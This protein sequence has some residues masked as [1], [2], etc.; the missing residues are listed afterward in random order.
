[1]ST[2]IRKVHLEYIGGSSYKEYNIIVTQKI[3][4][5]YDLKS[6]YGRIG[7]TQ[8]YR[9]IKLDIGLSQVMT[10]Y[11]SILRKKEKKGYEVIS[12]SD[13]S[14]FTYEYVEFLT[15]STNNLLDG[16]VIGIKHHDGILRL[17]KS[18]DNETLEMAEKIIF[19]NLKKLN[20][21]A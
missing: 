21:A 8:V 16:D 12:S 9:D 6:H 2:E 4:G 18:P 3:N 7:G 14:R 20:Q 5:L 19:A 10:E 15:K 17:L 13:A 11:K 1:M